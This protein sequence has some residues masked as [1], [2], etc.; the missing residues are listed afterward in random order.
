M[1]YIFFVF[2]FLTRSVSAEHAQVCASTRNPDVQRRAQSRAGVQA[3]PAKIPR[4][5]EPLAKACLPAKL[6]QPP[7][8]SAT[9]RC[10]PGPYQ[11]V[12]WPCGDSKRGR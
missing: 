8:S 2:F 9:Q 12:L 11:Y 4:C 1:T 6:C 10:K 7:Q 3:S 5:H